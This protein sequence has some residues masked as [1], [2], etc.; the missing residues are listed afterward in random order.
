MVPGDG[1]QPGPRLSRRGA[2]VERVRG[3]QED[4][5]RGVG[6]VLAIAQQAGA[7]T[8]DGTVI[9]LVQFSQPAALTRIQLM[10]GWPMGRRRRI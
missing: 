9:G 1:Q 10:N 4:V 3:D 7:E 5:L 8:Y 2:R 6:G